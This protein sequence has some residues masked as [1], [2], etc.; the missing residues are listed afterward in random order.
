[1]VNSAFVRLPTFFD[2]KFTLLAPTNK[3][4]RLPNSLRSKPALWG[5]R[6][7]SL[8]DNIQ[9]EFLDHAK[10]DAFIIEQVDNADEIRDL[11]IRLQSG[12][13]LNRQQVRDAWPGH[14]GPFIE[15]LAGKLN[16]EPSIP[17]FGL[18]DRRSDKG[19]EDVD[20]FTTNRQVCA[21]LLTL[22][23]ARQR[24]PLSVQSISADDLDQLYHSQTDFEG[25]GPTAECFKRVLTDAAKVFEEANAISSGSGKGKSKHRKLDVFAVCFVIQ[26]LLTNQ[27]VKIDR[28]LIK[29]LAAYVSS[30][31]PIAKGGKA[32]SGRVIAEY[33]ATWRQG[34]PDQLG[35]RLDPQRI[36]SEDQKAA[37]N[38]RDRGLCGI[39]GNTVPDGDA[40]Y[41]H[42]PTPHYLGGKTDIS[43]GRL[44]CAKCHPRGRPAA[45]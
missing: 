8:L 12:T 10:V 42:Y 11:F 29:K 3:Q 30:T 35:V 28:I 34:L 36:F 32:V 15:S 39:C 7:Y 23:L 31:A 19:D 41:D 24:D 17:L 18:I 20:S 14:V 2:G 44:V 26:D 38:L 22:F 33:Y 13:A 45:A 25:N 21:Q 9:R 6:T 40:E 4:L 37:I 16:R 1:M 43:N 27:Y 5:E